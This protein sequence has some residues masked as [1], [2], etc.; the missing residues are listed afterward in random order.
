MAALQACFP[1][2]LCNVIPTTLCHTPNLDLLRM[3]TSLQLV[4]PP[5][6]PPFGFAESAHSADPGIFSMEA[7]LAVFCA[8]VLAFAPSSCH[9]ADPEV[10]MDAVRTLLV[11]YFCKTVVLRLVCNWR[12][13]VILTPLLHLSL[14]ELPKALERAKPAGWLVNEREKLNVIRHVSSA[15]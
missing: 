5:V 7:T 1:S 6:K 3:R 14:A 12:R 9:G 13:S 15:C 10:N 8:V 11:F 2:E 4:H